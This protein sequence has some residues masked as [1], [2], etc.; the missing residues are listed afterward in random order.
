MDGKQVRWGQSIRVVRK[1]LPNL[2]AR[3]HL[4]N[5]DTNDDFAIRMRIVLSAQRRGLYINDSRLLYNANDPLYLHLA[6]HF[7]TIRNDPE[8]LVNDKATARSSIN[9]ETHRLRTR[10][11]EEFCTGFARACWTWLEA[12]QH[13][14]Y[15]DFLIAGQH[16]ATPIQSRRHLWLLEIEGTLHLHPWA[17][18]LLWWI[19]RYKDD[20]LPNNFDASQT[21]QTPAYQI[22]YN[23]QPFIKQE[24]LVIVTRKADGK[25]WEFSIYHHDAAVATTALE[26]LKAFVAKKHIF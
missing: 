9:Q 12:Y 21:I 16:L 2:S 1:E 3:F 15:E 8:A 11:T 19:R 18:F 4:T 7:I 25:E 23:F 22:H 17:Q 24:T 5:F 14:K 6:L 20:K 26:N 10:H 13:S